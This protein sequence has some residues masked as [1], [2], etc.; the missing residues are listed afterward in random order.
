MNDPVNYIDPLGLTPS[1][2]SITIQ[3]GD[4]LSERT[5]QYNKDNGTN[6]TWQEISDY[7]NLANP[8]K[9][10]AGDK[11]YI[12]VAK[13]AAANDTGSAIAVATPS[14]NGSASTNASRSSQ[15]SSGSFANQS[16][17]TPSI[18][19]DVDIDFGQ[20]LNG[21]QDIV[22][23]SGK[24]YI[25]LSG[26]AAFG[27]LSGALLADDVTGVG[28]LDD[29]I[30]VVTSGL[31]V[32]SGVL[33]L[34]GAKQAAEGFYE[35]ASSIHLAF[36]KKGGNPSE[37]VYKPSPKHNPDSGWG[38][39][40]PIPDTETGQELLDTAYSSSKNKQLYNIYKDKLIKFQPDNIEGWH[41][42]EVKNPSKEV[43]VDVFRQMLN[44]GLIDKTTY[45]KFIH[46]IY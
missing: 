43:P 10:F 5:A 40:N 7:N 42:Y 35:I 25:G 9:I 12:P 15:H 46:N 14:N 31:T 18:N 41:A 36:S 17:S 39:P 6:F 21:F 29:G 20:L 11:I 37:R 3:K 33:A 13:P 16:I 27:S 28:V 30:A 2:R 22:I 32:A 23:G 8:D 44:D 26:T 24:S 38:S 45:G 19:I 4:T 34:D 1:D